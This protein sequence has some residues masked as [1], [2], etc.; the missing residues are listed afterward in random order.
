MGA[1]C[2]GPETQKKTKGPMQ[3]CRFALGTPE[4]PGTCKNA[5]GVRGL[6]CADLNIKPRSCA[7]FR[8]DSESAHESSD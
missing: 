8:A 3:G 7:T 1:P 6:N 4:A 2:A 5:S